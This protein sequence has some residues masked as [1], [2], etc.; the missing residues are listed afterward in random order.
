MEVSSKVKRIKEQRYAFLLGCLASL[1]GLI[2]YIFARHKI[3]FPSQWLANVQENENKHRLFFSGVSVQ[4]QV[5]FFLGFF[6]QLFLSEKTDQ[7][8]FKK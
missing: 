1:A 3:P 4:L 2:F 7:V 8:K 5:N 6:F